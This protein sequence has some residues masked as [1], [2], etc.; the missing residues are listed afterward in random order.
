MPHKIWLDAGHGGKDSGAIGEQNRYEKDD[1][2]K[3][4]L[5]LE[6]QLKA[7]GI[8]VVMTRRED[9]SLSLAERTQLERDNNCSLAIACHR[10]SF[11]DTTAN[12][13]EIWLHSNAPQSYIA[14]ATEIALGIE[15]LG[16]KNRGVFKG[17]RDNPQANYYA[18]SGT[19]AP[20]M[21]IE[22]GFITNSSDN[23][24]FDTRLDK[25]CKVIAIASCRFLKLEYGEHI[26]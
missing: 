25:L 1:N 22:M 5:E 13:F 17:F 18:N 21:L 23:K 19:N 4:A 26:K 6:G 16:M 3:Y 10:N 24:I 15:K 2:L 7:Q 11:N 12:G 14:W 9:S 20:S 8:E